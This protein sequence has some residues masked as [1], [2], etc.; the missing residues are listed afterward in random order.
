MALKDDKIDFLP[1]E[2][3]LDKAKNFVSKFASFDEAQATDFFDSIDSLT[4]GIMLLH[5]P[6]RT[7]LDK[8]PYLPNIGVVSAK[9]AIDR[10]KPRLVLCGHFHENGGVVKLGETTFFNPG[11]LKDG[12]YGEIDFTATDVV[13]RYKRMRGYNVLHPMGWDAFGLPAEQYALKNN[14]HPEEF[15]R[16]NIEHFKKKYI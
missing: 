12:Y 3:C 2:E 10:L 16:K 14:V 1:L 8:L 13:A 5:S 11:A 6:V 4:N 7:V 15:T 9:K